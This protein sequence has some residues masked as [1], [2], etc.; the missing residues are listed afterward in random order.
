M[1][2]ADDL[3]VSGKGIIRLDHT[4]EKYTKLREIIIEYMKNNNY[5]RSEV[6]NPFLGTNFY[7]LSFMC[8]PPTVT[9]SIIQRIKRWLNLIHENEYLQIQYLESL[10][11]TRADIPFSINVEIRPAALKFWLSYI[12]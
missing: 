6:I 9:P 12:G 3:I 1:V 4:S 11:I 7:C 5:F 2:R 10:R 8:H